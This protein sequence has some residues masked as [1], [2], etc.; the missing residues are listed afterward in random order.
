VGAVAP[1]FSNQVHDYN[2]GIAENGLFWTIPFPDESAWIDLAAGK[3]EMHALGL[4]IPDTYTFGNAAA[5][6]PQEMARVS[7][8]VW[9]HSPMSTEHIQNEE[10]GFAAT[11]L[12]V[13]SAISFS[14]ESETFAFQ[15]D[16]PEKSQALYARIGYDAN[17]VFLPSDEGMA[18]PTA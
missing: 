15:S 9:W 4:E 12:E 17:G 18:T 8:D 13:E 16:P 1:D 3:A 5:R 11:L 14:A 2:P 7:F 10:Q 6:G